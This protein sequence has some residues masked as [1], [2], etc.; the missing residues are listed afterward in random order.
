MFRSCFPGKRS[1]ANGLRHAPV[2]KAP[3]DSNTTCSDQLLAHGR[4]VT[5]GSVLWA[6]AVLPRDNPAHRMGPAT[7]ALAVA[8]SAFFGR[9]QLKLC[10]LFLG[11]S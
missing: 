11:G 10:C 8:F 3:L 9:C 2:L 7:V 4:T 1:P 6:F 5:P